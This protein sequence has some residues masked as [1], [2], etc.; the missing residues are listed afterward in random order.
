MKET[1][2]P[3]Q[4]IIDILKQYALGEKTHGFKHAYEVEELV[5]EIAKE[6]EFS[7]NELDLTVLSAAALLH[8][9]GYSRSKP[10]WKQGQTEHVIESINIARE[11]LSNVSP[12]STDPDRL[13][14]VCF[15][16]RYHDEINHAFPIYDSKKKLAYPIITK[17]VDTEWPFIYI[18]E[19]KKAEVML[20]ILKEA[21]ART[22][23]GTDGATKTWEYSISRKIPPISLN[24]GDP[25]NA[26][27][28]EESAAGNVRL[29]AKRAILDAF[30]ETGKKVV[31]QNYLQAEEVIKQKTKHIT[32]YQPEVHLHQ[33]KNI[34]PS[35]DYDRF[36]IRR[37][38]PWHEFERAL[39]SIKL[40]GDECL[41]PYRE[42]I[43]ENKLVEIDE[44]LPTAFYISRADLRKVERLCE[45]LLKHYCLSPF[46]MS[47][48]IDIS[49]YK[50]KSRRIDVRT[51]PPI[52]E[53]YT[54][55]KGKY[56]GKQVAALVD[57][58][59]RCYLAKLQGFTRVRAIVISNIPKNMPLV[60][61]PLSWNEVKVFDGV[62]EVKR[63]YRFKDIDDFPNISS[64][65]SVEITPKNFKYFFYRDLKPIGSEGV[66]KTPKRK[67]GE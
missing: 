30:T 11:T 24:K 27:Y 34:S 52:I 2:L 37:V 46:D 36:W 20:K 22:S 58:L 48:M 39:R 55:S 53:V 42:A 21:D 57:G 43:I 44:L 33:L 28:W 50:L 64:F 25:F 15:L 49:N 1:D 14:L 4:E 45:D 10:G 26:W 41:M 35:G 7:L 17:Q 29:A 12:F 47:T 13:R 63:D 3:Q 65:S 31:W 8:D 9:V 23:T 19:Y 62:P 18:S 6:P 5:K 40:Q 56:M 54:E 59:H 67:T 51:T 66:R 38:Y 16:I 32:T 61:L 60:P